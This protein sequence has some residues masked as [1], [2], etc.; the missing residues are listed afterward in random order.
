M[1]YPKEFVIGVDVGTLSSRAGILDLKGS[2][3]G[4]AIFPIS[5][6]YPKPDFVE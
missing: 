5:I 4:C 1:E 3:M 6:Y 2:M